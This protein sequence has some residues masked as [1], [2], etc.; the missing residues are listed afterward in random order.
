MWFKKQHIYIP[1][2]IFIDKLA[3]IPEKS[4]LPKGKLGIF[5]FALSPICLEQKVSFS[6]VDICLSCGTDHHF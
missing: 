2:Y 6:W 3:N 5:G 1:V 4:F